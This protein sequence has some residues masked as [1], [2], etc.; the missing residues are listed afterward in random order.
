MFS[1]FYYICAF[2]SVFLVI[3]KYLLFFLAG[4]F[5]FYKDFA[6]ENNRYFVTFK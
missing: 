6:R 5:V 4:T 1:A 3:Q 2:I